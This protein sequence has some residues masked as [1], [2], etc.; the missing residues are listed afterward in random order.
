M[1]ER[2]ELLQIMAR[3][4]WCPCFVEKL[5]LNSHTTSQCYFIVIQTDEKSTA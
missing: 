3:V 2:D 5:T 1:V 4:A